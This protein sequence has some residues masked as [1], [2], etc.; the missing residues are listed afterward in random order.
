M[1]FRSLVSL[2]SIAGALFVTLAAGQ[3]QSPAKPAQPPGQA[4]DLFDGK[5]LNGWRGYK[6]P[7]ATGSRWIVQ[8]GMLTLPTHDGKD[9]RGARDI[10]SVET[11]DLFELS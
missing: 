1:R 9:T 2:T 4:T 11:F 3:A 5:S 8:E 7:D 6:K 10:I